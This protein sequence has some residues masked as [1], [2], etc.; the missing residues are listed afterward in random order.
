M[1]EFAIDE[2]EKAFELFGDDDSADEPPVPARQALAI[3]RTEPA[4]PPDIDAQVVLLGRS[5]SRT[6]RS[7]AGAGSSRRATC[8]PARCS[9]PSAGAG[10]AAGAVRLGAMALRGARAA[11]CAARGRVT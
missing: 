3:P 7:A 11:R 5:R 10:P 4:L 9:S 8:R 2:V 1:A 6:A